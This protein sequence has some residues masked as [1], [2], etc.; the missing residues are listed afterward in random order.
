MRKPLLFGL[1]AIILSGL[2]VF[3]AMEITLRVIFHESMNFDIEMWKY[4]RAV[5]RLATDP[6]IGHEHTPGTRGFLM[7]ADVQINEH[8]YRD[9]SFPAAKPGREIRVAMLG[10]SLTFG[11][12]V[13]AKD[14]PSALLGATL[15]ARHLEHTVRVINMGVGNYN[16]AM[17]VSAFLAR[18]LT[19]QPDIVVLNYFI[20]DAEPQPPQRRGNFLSWSY[21]Y[22]FLIGRFDILNRQL[23][24]R[25]DWR[26]YYGNLYTPDAAGWRDARAAIQRLTAALKERGI[27]LL[28]AN[29]PELHILGDKYPFPFVAAELAKLARELNVGFIDLSPALAS[30]APETLWVSPTDPH[31]NAKANELMTKLLYDEVSAM[32]DAFR[33]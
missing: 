20:N 4:A 7:G 15:K 23:A 9:A 26:T 13:A 11:W 22:I 29:Y 1:G 19:L 17:E 3:A 27:P 10:D 28:I 6:A 16:T 25:E 31:P 2:G 21:A 8:G 14:T 18:G 32:V 24:V 5:K 30:E 33:N 12:G